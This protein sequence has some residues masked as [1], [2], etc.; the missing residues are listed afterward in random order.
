MVQLD[1]GTT[2][3]ES[4]IS[5]LI[6]EFVARGV[7]WG[8][9]HFLIPSF[10]SYIKGFFERPNGKHAVSIHEL[11]IGIFH[12]EKVQDIIKRWVVLICIYCW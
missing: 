10:G 5:T 3:P 6:G 12:H 1:P 2:I 4:G 8:G 7:S 11:L 9:G